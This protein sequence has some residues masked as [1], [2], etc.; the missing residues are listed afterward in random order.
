MRS[1]KPWL[2]AALTVCLGA[3]MTVQATP[4][5][6]HVTW[7]PAMPAPPVEEFL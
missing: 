1:F 2:A 5:L 3:C 6:P 7:E 4:H